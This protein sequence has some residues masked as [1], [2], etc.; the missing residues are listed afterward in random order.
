M[1]SAMR[2]VSTQVC[3]PIFLSLI[4]TLIF[5]CPAENFD[6]ILF[7]FLFCLDVFCFVMHSQLLKFSTKLFFFFNNYRHSPGYHA[8]PNTDLCLACWALHLAGRTK[9]ALRPIPRRDF[10][11]FCPARPPPPVVAPARKPQPPIYAGAPA[12]LLALYDRNVNLNRPAR[13][14]F[15]SFPFMW[16]SSGF[17]T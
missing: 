1:T 9:P 8:E 13:Y 14:T 3:Y 6:C 7:V 5:A 17:P 16:T 15:F 4:F 12:F 10:I 2:K 11:S